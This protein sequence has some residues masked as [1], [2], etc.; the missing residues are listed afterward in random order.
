V[1]TNVLKNILMMEMN[2]C[3]KPNFPVNSLWT[4]FGVLKVLWDK[5]IYDRGDKKIWH[6]DK[7]IYRLG[8]KKFISLRD[9]KIY[10]DDKKNLS[11]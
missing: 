4:V 2:Y 6:D 3:F 10:D 5:K 7:K 11:I 8:D 9:K 1:L